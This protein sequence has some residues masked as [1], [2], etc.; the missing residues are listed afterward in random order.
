MR[1][2]IEDGLAA[3][4]VD[5]RY[6]KG[7]MPHADQS[8][9]S[10]RARIITFLEQVYNSQGENLPDARDDPADESLGLWVKSFS[11]KDHQKDLGHDPYAD[12]L[13][14][15][16]QEKPSTPKWRKLRK[17]LDFQLSMIF[18]N[19]DGG[20]G[21]YAFWFQAPKAVD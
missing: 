4:P 3:P 9:D 20:A 6:L 16:V 2:A 12:A 21:G 18:E 7:E 11:L 13:L 10:Q 5:L 1:K 19:F 15:A 14:A 8:G 17:T